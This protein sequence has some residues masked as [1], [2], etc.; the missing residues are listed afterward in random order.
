MLIASGLNVVEAARRLGHSPAMC[1]STYAHV[2]DE[3]EG[4]RID[5]DFE[6]AEARGS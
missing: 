4:R 1:L 2:F 3:Y 5:L 6:I